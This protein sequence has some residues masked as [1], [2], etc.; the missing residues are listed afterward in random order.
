MRADEQTSQHLL[1]AVITTVFS[2]MLSLITVFMAW[3][4]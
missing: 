3:E 1:L 4:F 2:A